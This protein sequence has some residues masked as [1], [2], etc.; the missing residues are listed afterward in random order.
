M[1]FVVHGFVAARLVC[2][3]VSRCD[4]VETNTHITIFYENKNNEIELKFKMK[5][6]NANK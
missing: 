5:K 6:K 1:R 4:Y 3:R 2:E